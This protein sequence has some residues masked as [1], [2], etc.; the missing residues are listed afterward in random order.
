MQL[1]WTYCNF[2]FV[3]D[4]EAAN[5]S[6][7]ISTE[8]VPLFVE[9][10][11]FV[12]SMTYGM[13][14]MLTVGLSILPSR[15]GIQIMYDKAGGTKHAMIVMGLPF[16]YYW[17]G[18]FCMNYL[19][20]LFGNGVMCVC[21]A[22]F[23]PL[24]WSFAIVPV[25][26]CA[27][28]YSAS[29]LLYAYFLSQL[30][31]N[32][33]AYGMTL[34]LTGMFFALCPAYLVSVFA[35]A[36]HSGARWSSLMFLTHAFSSFLLPPYNPIGVLTGCAVVMTSYQQKG[37]V[38]KLIDYFAWDRL[39][40]WS[41]FGTIFQATVLFAATVYIDR[42]HYTGRRAQAAAT[43]LLTAYYKRREA[44]RQEW[45]RRVGGHQLL[46]PASLQDHKDE[47][48]YSEE[49]E[50]MKIM[51]VLDGQE[52]AY[53][54][55]TTEEDKQHLSNTFKW[56]AAEDPEFPSELPLV[57]IDDLHYMFMPTTR[58]QLPHVAVRGFSL[59][60]YRGD[61]FGLLGPNGAGKTTSLNLLTC[62]YMTAAP[63]RGRALVGGHD[64][65][66]NPSLAFSHLGLCPQ[67]DALWGDITV[68]DNIRIFARI[69]HVVKVY[70]VFFLIMLRR[71]L[72]FTAV[73]ERFLSL[74]FLFAHVYYFLVFRRN[75]IAWWTDTYAIWI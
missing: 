3:S 31:Y 67:F 5:N 69:K 28:F 74:L 56:M 36:A 65:C 66:V 48:V 20:M 4:A 17:L 11:T 40:I 61:I 53:A 35:D 47:D 51:S 18:S 22:Y 41:I 71:R 21:I 42:R 70:C 46:I 2:C 8:S 1:L 19:A 7:R 63:T 60:V 64:I 75:W 29:V 32:L 43:D 13:Y 62:H 15:F 54:E 23:I 50:C 16:S 44:R 25:I 68:R 30:F 52:R 24:F 12:T 37:L 59:R 9:I 34:Q 72:T 49:K 6:P 14:I 27:L 55:A 57:L 38:P 39:P 73:A 58:E 10:P 33:K 26:I 45:L